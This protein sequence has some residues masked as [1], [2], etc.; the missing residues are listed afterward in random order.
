VPAAASPR[1]PLPI[2]VSVRV[3][4]VDPNDVGQVNATTATATAP[5][6]RIRKRRIVE[7]P[8]LFALLD[9]S[10]A[11][12]R[13]LVA[14]AGYGKTTLAEQWVVRDGRQA[15]WF[16][17]RSSATDVAALALGIA[18]SAKLFIED[19]DVRLRAHL[20]ALPA[21][22]ESP[23]TLAEILG[24]DL[25]KWPADTWLVIDDYHEIAEEP[26][27]EDFVET[28][29]AVSRIPFLIASR[30]RPA[31][32]TTKELMYGSAFEVNQT[33]LAMDATEAAAVLVGRS[34][35]SA[36]GL[37]QLANGWPAVIGLASVSSAEID[38]DVEQVPESLYRYFADEV[39]SSLGPDIRQGLT[40]L[41]VAPL[42]DI[43]LATAI[44]GEDAADQVCT[45]ALDVGLLV[46]RGSNLDLHPLA[47][48]FLEERSAQLGLVPA[49]HAADTCL[50]AYRA[51][52]EWDAA[53]ELITPTDAI[54]ELEGL[55]RE[56]LD[57]LLDTARLSTLERW[58]DEAQEKGLRAPIFSLAHAEVMLRQGR[59]VQAVAHA[60]SAAAADPMLHFRASMLAGR[61]A[62]L[63]SREE[64]ALALF[65]R[66][67]GVAS[68][69][70]EHRDARWGQLMCLIDLE[71]PGS[72][73]LLSEMT[74]GVS[75]ADAREMI[76]AAAH[77]LYYQLRQGTLDLEDADVACELLGNVDDPLV[78]SSFL[79]AHTIA[80]SLTGRYREAYEAAET[81]LYIAEKYRFGFAFLYG[82]CGRAVALGGMR[83]WRDAERDVSRALGRAHSVRDRNAGLVASSILLRLLAQ[84]GRFSEALA[85][86]IGSTRG[87]LKAAASELLGSRALAMACVGRTREANQLVDEIEGT[88]TAVEPV[89]LIPAVRA[90]CALRDTAPDAVERA[91]HLEHVAFEIGAVD[92]L[93]VAYRACPDLL[94]VLLRVTQHRRFPELLEKV[95]DA[96]LAAVIGRP[97]A[98]ND[99][100][101]L[102][103]SRREREVYELLRSG[104]TNRQIAKLLYIEPSTVKAHT[105]RIYDKLG[106]RSRSALA[107]QAALERS[108]QAT[109]A[110]GSASEANS[111]SSE[112]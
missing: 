80:L 107:V 15:T 27:A 53:F 77:G 97:I 56:A 11:P 112:L 71:V 58:C 22:A 25:A 55:L 88:S 6:A 51:R 3:E 23:E 101:R 65:K 61:A 32:I 70:G 94:S 63:A 99:D 28:L 38:E 108:D 89:V 73:A 39:F 8:R 100:R 81:L 76:R 83:R 33:A 79:S 60:E 34:E 68:S 54:R 103:L 62:H 7:R 44:L 84:Q 12:V 52:R 36:A 106:V 111:G 14:P 102:L 96:D 17:A 104:L 10:K 13:T 30:V 105:H 66:A 98:V 20:R 85:F 46:E 110:T 69:D 29:V 72:E 21:P 87:A 42:L 75:F 26:R 50:R 86:P 45:A 74:E 57:E 9:G 5:A 92:L 1:A 37:V 49:E 109:S 59:Y 35:R 43:E 18:R 40:T 41:A 95:G 31:W 82:L 48:A 67:E 90:I 16:R 19:C 64:Q 4:L 91:T 47:R 93:V 24:E 2:E 78:E